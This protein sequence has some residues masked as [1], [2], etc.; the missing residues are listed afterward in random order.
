VEPLAPKTTLQHHYKVIGRGVAAMLNRWLMKAAEYGLDRLSIVLLVL[1]ALGGSLV[2][3]FGVAIFL[4]IAQ[5]IQ[6]DGDLGALSASS[7]LWRTAIVWAEQLGV[8]L[9]IEILLGVAAMLFLFR[10]IFM[11]LRTIYFA[12]VKASLLMKM[13]N[14]LLKTYADAD[15]EYHDRL[16]SGGLHTMLTA[17]VGSA[18]SWLVGP[19]EIISLLI[20]NFMY[21]GLLFFLS[22][23]M[24][25]VVVV[26][27]LLAMVSVRRWV[28]QSKT[29]G[30]RTVANNIQIGEF[31]G[32]RLRSWRFPRLANTELA[33][34]HE[35]GSLTKVTAKV[36][37]SAQ[38]LAAKT[39]AVIEPVVIFS[40]IFFLYLGISFFDLE[41]E[42]IG[43]FAIV[44]LRLTPVG[45]ILVEKIQ[46]LNR[47]RGSIEILDKRL[48]EMSQ[49]KEDKSHAGRI[50]EEIRQI[51]IVELGYMYPNSSH[52]ALESISCELT[53]KT[54]VAIVGPSGGGKST[55]IDLIPRLRVAKKG[56]ILVNGIPI[57]DI[58]LSSLRSAISYLPQYPQIFSGT[59]AAHVSYGKKGAT[60][61]EIERALTLAGATEFVRR[62]PQ[63][64]ETEVGELGVRLSGGQRQRLD[65]ARA[66]LSE[67]SVLIL[68][69]P[70]SSL[71]AQSVEIFSNVL[72][73]LRESTALLVIMI[74]HELSLAKRADKI[75][76]L[77]DGRLEA[78]GDH[79]TLMAASNWYSQSLKS[80]SSS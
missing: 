27:L 20:L 56:D 70:T 33:E 11:Y 12:S 4:P 36:T 19:I 72:R 42:S 79:Q 8:V 75:L 64:I 39:E 50:L 13:R 48:G 77:R 9:R 58:Q 49:A 26:L 51:K 52:P 65:L 76:V 32:Q 67:G 69:E 55:L 62:L 66:L 71:D 3:V 68:D 45:K 60:A 63:G 38:V 53:A 78:A 18:V 23:T 10:Q 54:L 80:A 21:L 34:L 24:T 37:V 22:W 74:T 73:R 43:V 41:I 47:I 61:Q 25:L 1:F 28:I 17:E 6:A 40:S 57:I 14:N 31:L 7:D 15:T 46:G 44:A 35:F 16:A 29:L 59:V 2:E 5:M 30:R